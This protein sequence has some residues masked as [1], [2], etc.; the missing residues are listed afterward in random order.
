MNIVARQIWSMKSASLFNP[1]ELI[2]F[3]K[4]MDS[5]IINSMMIAN[6]TVFS[7][8][9]L[10]SS[11]KP[12]CVYGWFQD[13]KA[14][15]KKSIRRLSVDC[16]MGNIV[17]S[18]CWCNRGLEVVAKNQEN[19]SSS[20]DFFSYLCIG[21]V[22]FLLSWE[23][24]RGNKKVWYKMPKKFALWFCCYIQPCV[25][26]YLE[27]CLLTCCEW[28]QCHRLGEQQ[29]YVKLLADS[30]IN[31]VKCGESEV[32]YRW[33]KKRGLVCALQYHELSA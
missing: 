6:A 5:K 3:A 25:Q 1:L 29:F 9:E 19:K 22:M 26:F 30:F 20:K 10:L 24:R 13:C 14:R 17:V 33:N 16:D 7:I 18:Y 28:R 31:F 27:I 12:F 32:I 4:M 2:S 11:Q 23:E 15:L 8:K 21:F